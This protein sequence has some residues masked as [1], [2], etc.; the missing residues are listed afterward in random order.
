MTNKRA[1]IRW[2]TVEE[3]G[4]KVLPPGPQY[5]APAKFLAHAENWGEE[6]WSLVVNKDEESG[7]PSNWIARVHFWS[8]NGPHEW[9]QLGAE[10][11]LYEGKQHVA[12]GRIG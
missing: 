9:L 5:I 1:T 10:F 8:E 12:F 6:V 4:R 11:E 7:S 3:G 2:L